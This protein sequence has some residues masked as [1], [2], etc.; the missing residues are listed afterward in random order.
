MDLILRPARRADVAALSR[1]GSESFVAKFGHLYRPADLA[2]YLA[3][4]HSE[5]AVAG[6]LA[7]RARRCCLAEADGRL[8]G[9][10]RLALACG[11]P[12]YA[13]GGHVIELKQLY[14]DPALTGQ[15]IGA[16]LMEWALAE[17]RMH[18]ADEI[19]LSVWSEN[20]G[21]QAFYAR[22]GFS[23]VAE[24]TFAVGEQIDEE[25]LFARLL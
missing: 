24:V 2:A 14:T 11:W 15:G 20:H 16:R 13:R 19:Q 25:Y 10:C 21:A 1:L 17:A 8:A 7:N 23:K 22:Y 12:Q 5:D 9:Y 4:A 6:D 3:Q 18:G